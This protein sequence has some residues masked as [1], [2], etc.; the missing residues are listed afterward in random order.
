MENLCIG[1][2]KPPRRNERRRQREQKRNPYKGV[3]SWADTK[4]NDGT[5]DGTFSALTIKTASFSLGKPFSMRFPA[6]EPNR[7]FQWKRSIFDIPSIRAMDSQDD[8]ICLWPVNHRTVSAA[9]APPLHPAGPRSV[10]ELDACPVKLRRRLAQDARPAVGRRIE[11]AGNITRLVTFP[12][13]ETDAWK[14]REEARRARQTPPRP[15][16]TYLATGDALRTSK[17]ESMFHAVNIHV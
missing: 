4:R 6:E 12:L 5:F 2:H 8:D 3:A 15:G 11:H 17:R 14:E 1:H 7:L 16:K 13:C 10:F 9:L